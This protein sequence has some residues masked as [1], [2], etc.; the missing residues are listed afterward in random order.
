[1]LTKHT[2]SLLLLSFLLL[3]FSFFREISGPYGDSGDKRLVILFCY[4]IF[5]K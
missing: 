1:M 3:G 2:R 5:E 4:E